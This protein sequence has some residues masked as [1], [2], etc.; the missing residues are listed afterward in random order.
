[1]GSRRFPAG[2]PPAP[3]YGTAV[4]GPLYD[5]PGFFAA[6]SQLPRS[7]EGL[8][9]APEWPSLRALLPP[10]AGCD[11]LDLGC[12]FGWFCRWAAAQGAARVVGLDVSARM[13]ARAAADTDDGRIAYERADLDAV[14]LPPGAFDVAYSSLAFHYLAHLDRLL[15]AV[16]GA[17]RPGAPLVFSVEHPVYTAPRRPGFVT[18]DAGTPVWALDG[19]LDEGER[20]TDWLAPGVVKR[21]RTIG[22]YVRLLRDAGFTLTDLVEWGPSAEQVSEHPAW[23]PEVERPPFLLVAARRD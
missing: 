13:L 18:S 17:L 7:V 8:A 6:Y 5:E 22:T 21:H 3:T 10:L 11:V 2:P 14:T 4:A 1:M 20:V 15:V 12:G 9:G 19:Y 16:A 23:A